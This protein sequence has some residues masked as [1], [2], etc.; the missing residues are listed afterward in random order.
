MQA[1]ALGSGWIDGDVGTGRRTA[2]RIPTATSSSCS[3]WRSG[4]WPSAPR[5]VV[6]QPAPGY[7]GRGAAVKRLDH[8]NMLAADVRPT[9]TFCQ[10]VLGY[11]LYERIELEDARETGAWLSVSIAAH[12]LI[13]VADAYGARARRLPS[14]HAFWVDTREECLRAADIFVGRGSSRSWPRRRSTES[15]RVLPY[16]LEPGGN[17]I[18]VPPAATSCTTPTSSRSPGAPRSGRAVITGASRRST[19]FTPTAPP[20]SPT[21]KE[22][23]H[24]WS[25]RSLEGRPA[26][27]RKRGRADAELATRP[28]RLPGV[29]AE[30]TNWRGRAGSRGARTCAL[31]DQSHHMTDLYLEGPDV[32]RL[33]YDL[34][35]NTF[36]NAAVDKGEAVRRLQHTTAT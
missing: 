14:P 21:R 25:E 2:S 17:R 26:G 19:A 5:A 20:M 23:G 24:T 33:L 16:G 8:V 1:T 35:V 4:T 34:G 13:Y 9:R 32:I 15:A 30:F 11:R 3:T 27:G 31:F 12:E 36:A 28:V 22:A 6:A 29:P 7:V 10:D 18:E